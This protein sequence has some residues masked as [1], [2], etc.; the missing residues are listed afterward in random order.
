M[1]ILGFRVNGFETPISKF[2]IGFSEVD[3]QILP[4]FCQ[5]FERFWHD[6]FNFL[7]L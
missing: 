1:P 4:A 5:H 3:F 7:G 6:F 2:G